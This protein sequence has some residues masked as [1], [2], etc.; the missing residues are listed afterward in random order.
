MGAAHQ[1][2]TAYCNDFDR[3]QYARTIFKKE[4]S[5]DR[6]EFCKLIFGDIADL[7]LYEGSGREKKYNLIIS[8]PDTSKNNNYHRIDGEKIFSELDIFRYYTYR[9]Q[10]M[11]AKGG[12][13]CVIMLAF[14]AREIQADDKNYDLLREYNCFLEAMISPTRFNYSVLIFKK[15]WIVFIRWFME[16]PEEYI[17]LPPNN[18]VDIIHYV[19]VRL[20]TPDE[21]LYPNITKFI[22]D[23]NNRC[24]MVF[25]IIAG[26]YSNGG[27]YDEALIAI[28]Q[29]T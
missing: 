23:V 24:K 19:R 1:L 6:K 8:I 25:T 27:S 21:Q 2:I 14:A 22:R 20:S 7:F 10:C 5:A 4:Y 13:L 17:K 16:M 3:Y 29:T 26:M 9:P 18:R 12:Y 28:E 11:L 15:Y